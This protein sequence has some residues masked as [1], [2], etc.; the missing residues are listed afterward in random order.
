MSTFE[1][2]V[3]K[4][5]RILPHGNA[6][7]LELAEVE[8]LAYQFVIPRQS[9]KPGDDVVYFPIDSLLPD[10][11]SVK[12]GVKNYLAGRERNRVKTVKLRGAVSQGIVARPG[13]VREGWTYE[14]GVDYKDLLGVV[15][16]DPPPIQSH[17]GL[18]RPLPPGVEVYDIESADNFVEVAA[19]LMDEPVFVTEKLE[20]SNWSATVLPDGATFVSQHRYRIEPVEGETHS[21]W[22]IA[23]DQGLLDALGRLS[24]QFGGRQVTI[25]GEYVGP[26]VQKNIYQLKRNRV[27]LFDIEVGGVPL[28]APKFLE[29]SQALGLETVPVLAIG[30]N[31]RAWLGGDDLRRKSNGESRLCPGVAREGIVIKPQ[32]ERRHPKIGRLF[33]KQRSPEYLAASEF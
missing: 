19:L 23:A 28:D 11:L 3:R 27:F 21:F 22:K 14:I 30:E 12:L 25:R 6:D 13:A 8:G 32:V 9:L 10:E 2:A 24:S 15:K 17:A 29:T 33:L 18:L 31:L 1:V 4:I 20:G 26:G 16:H 7:K 5:S